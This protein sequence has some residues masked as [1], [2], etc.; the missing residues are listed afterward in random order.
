MRKK[1]A[2]TLIELLAIIVI[3]AIIAVIT[4]PIIL[5]IIENSR[6]GAAQDSAYGFKDA[7]NKYYVTELSSNRQF[8]LEGEYTVADGK[9]KGNNI[10]DTNG[11]EIPTSG[12]KPSNGYLNY[13]NNTLTGGCLVFGDY[14]V[15]FDSNGSVSNTQKGICLVKYTV[16]FNSNGGSNVDAKE[17]V[18]GTTVQ[19]PTNVTKE[20]MALDGWY[21]DETFADDKKFNFNSTVN[22]NMTLYAKWLQLQDFSFCGES[23]CWNTTFYNFVNTYSNNITKITVSN[24]IDIPTGATHFDFSDNENVKVWLED[25]GN[26]GMYELKIGANG[27]PHPQ[28]SMDGIFGMLPSLS[29]VNFDGMDASRV[30]DMSYL[31]GSSFNS[32]NNVTVD[33]GNNFNANNAEITGMFNCAG[34]Y[35]TEHVDINLGNNFNAVNALDA[36]D[37][38]TIGAD[39]VNIDLGNNF[40]AVNLKNAYQMFGYGSSSRTI[41]LGNNFGGQNITSAGQMFSD[42]SFDVLDISSMNLSNIKG[43]YQYYDM[44]NRISANKIYVKD[45]NDQNWLIEKGTENYWNGNGFE[46]DASHIL[47][48]GQN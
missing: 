31:F 21:T 46:F 9:L 19:E 40:N 6:K 17:V 14:E 39:G 3:L 11:V 28:G 26:N 48:K 36:E 1:N 47:V 43:Y 30:T 25:D 38:F 18:A 44:F 35:T 37:M 13:S 12:A 45:V 20:N 41:N 23:Q 15:I 24:K 42:L 4:V 8:Q 5:N 29:Y 16:T 22:S 27:I 32:V 7:V 10:S 2:F 34:G 33:F